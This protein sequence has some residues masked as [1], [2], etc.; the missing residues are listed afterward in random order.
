MAD[1]YTQTPSQIASEFSTICP[2]FTQE[3]LSLVAPPGTTSVQVQ[4]VNTP[5]QVTPGTSVVQFDTGGSLDLS[6]LPSSVQVIVFTQA[7]VINGRPYQGV[8]LCS[9][10]NDLIDFSGW[11][12]PAPG[13]FGLPEGVSIDPGGGMNTIVGSGGSDTICNGPGAKNTVDA[14]GGVDTLMVAGSVSDFQFG[15]AGHI[16]E[17]IGTNGTDIV[18]T[19][20]EI[21][22]FNDG[23]VV[24]GANVNEVAL[25][26]LYQ[27]FF[28]R[29]PDAGGMQYWLEDMRA[30]G[31]TVVDAAWQFMYS[32]EGLADGI[33]T[34]TDSQYIDM[35][36]ENG[37][38]R[39]PDDGGK[40]YWLQ[41]MANGMSRAEVAA[42]FAY[43]P[44]S[45]A[46]IT[47]VYL[48]TQNGAEFQVPAAAADQPDIVITGVSLDIITGVV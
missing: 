8:Y 31:M 38:N 46:V 14:A 35:L 32:E 27:L 2:T 34:M 21:L 7:V 22:Q 45:Y 5:G 28:D 44:E 4:A 12:P 16:F 10:G 41:Q 26:H 6:Q 1:S 42:Q 17:A 39:A 3:I 11:G 37:F 13:W 19:Y 23:V 20:G 43:S 15:V 30:T 36:Y 29:D 47:N 33:P 25:A 48:V 24:T 9:D 40:S 18:M